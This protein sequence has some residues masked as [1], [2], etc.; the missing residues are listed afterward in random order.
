VAGVDLV[1]T[2]PC[3]V[4]HINVSVGSSADPSRNS[5]GDASAFGW[6]VDSTPFVVVTMLSDCTGMV[7]GETAIR[8]GS[9]EIVKVRGPTMVGHEKVYF[10]PLEQTR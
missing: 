9:G 7:G 2:L 1:P 5:S 3:D 10:A 6:H 4:G 8:T